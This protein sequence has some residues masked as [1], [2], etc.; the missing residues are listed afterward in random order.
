MPAPPSPWLPVRGPGVWVVCVCASCASSHARTHS[1]HP[2]DPHDPHPTHTPHTH[3]AGIA[4][5]ILGLESLSGFL[6]YALA[7]ALLSALLVGLGTRGQPLAH[8][9]TPEPVWVGE[10]GENTFSFV[11]FWTLA[12]GLVHIYE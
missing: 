3:R 11:L 4:C 7:S 9:P 12:Y 8:F 5:G 1:H 10:V 2:F 6:F